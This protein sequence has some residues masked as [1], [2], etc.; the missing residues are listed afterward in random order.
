MAIS[1]REQR[2]LAIAALCKLDKQ[3]GVWLVPSQS[4][5]G[6]YQVH[7]HGDDCRCT[8]PDFEKRGQKC[9]HIY[10]VEYT[11]EREV[12]GDGSETLTRSLTIT[13]KITYPQVWPAYN[14]AQ[15]HEKERFQVLLADLCSMVPEPDRAGRRGRRPHFVK[16]ML[17]A[18]VYKVYSTFSARRFST[19]LREAHGR[20][21]IS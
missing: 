1:E 6:Q 9:K 5:N 11:I 14:E 7:H 19:D 18:M 20:G 21:Y 12:H 16:D 3:D 10:A 2:G 15:A 13:E 17:F 8:C 4:A